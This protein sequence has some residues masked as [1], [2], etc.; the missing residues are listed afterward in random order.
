MA[1]TI[2]L[3]LGLAV[4]LVTGCARAPPRGA[5]SSPSSAGASAPEPLS[6]DGEGRASAPPPSSIPHEPAG[7]CEARLGADRLRRSAVKR[8]VDAGLGRWLQAIAI[9]PLL[10][11]GH[12]KGW[13]I[14]AL[15]ANDSCYIGVDLRAGDVVTRINGRSIERPEQAMEVWTSLPASSELVVD[16]LRDGHAR[17]LRLGIVDQ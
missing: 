2:F 4:P 10:A 14:R 9:D 7:A 17:T 12:F 16:F 5:G 6:S 1:E 15:P 11:R 8:T 13:I 3:V